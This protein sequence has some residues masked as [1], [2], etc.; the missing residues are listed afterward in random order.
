[1]K[2]TEQLAAILDRHLDQFEALAKK[3]NALEARLNEA[4]K[5]RE[6]WALHYKDIDLRSTES[7]NKVD[8]MKSEFFDLKIEIK[9]A[10]KLAND[11]LY[12]VPKT[13]KEVEEIIFNKVNAEIRKNQRLIVKQ[14]MENF[15]LQMVMGLQSNE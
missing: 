9:K 7:V 10:V 13:A 2:D 8:K 15:K 14:E 6:E 1:M 4:E 11:S 5:R 12:Y 3:V